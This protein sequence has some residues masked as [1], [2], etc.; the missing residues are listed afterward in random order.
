MEGFDFTLD[1]TLHVWLL[2]INHRP[3]MRLDVLGS[4][5][6]PRKSPKGWKGDAK[7]RLL[8][9]GRRSFRFDVDYYT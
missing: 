6:S 8:A 3:G 9:P 5:Y 2:E 7:R 4:S 1:E